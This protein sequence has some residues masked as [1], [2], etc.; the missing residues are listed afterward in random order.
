MALNWVSKKDLEDFKAYILVEK[1]FSEY[2]AKA[3]CSDILSYLI[4]LGDE[5]CE[6][7]DFSK[8]RDY[9]HF[10]QKFDYKKNYKFS[11][12]ATWWIRQAIARA[13]ANTSKA[14]RIPVHMA[15]KIK[16]YNFALNYLSD[17]L[18]RLPENHE[19]AE[20]MGL[21][22]KQLEKIQHSIILEPLSLE[23]AVTDDLCIGD[24]IEDTSHLSPEENLD[25]KCLKNSIPKLLNVVTP[26]E[27][28]VL[29]QRFGINENKSKT[30][31][32]IGNSLGYSKERIR[33]LECSAL[34]KIRQNL[35]TKHYKDFIKY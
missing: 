28:E 25:E 31:L 35:K 23:T 21:S 8:I 27:K 13:I 20:F 4:W 16:K 2:T 7:A 3:Y 19:I 1:N 22:E 11:T 32:D 12:Y 17:K 26:K 10:M 18:N 30:L 33:Q 5:G 24:F 29:K 14:I 9:L 34:A 15:D 6:G